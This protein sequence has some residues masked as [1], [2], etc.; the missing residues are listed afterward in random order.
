MIGL[1]N[2]RADLLVPDLPG[3]AGDG[4][5]GGVRHLDQAELRR[6]AVPGLGARDRLA[7]AGGLRGADPRLVPRHDGALRGGGEVPRLANLQ[8]RTVLAGQET[9]GW[10]N[11]HIYLLRFQHECVSK[12]L[13]FTVSACRYQQ[14]VHLQKQSN[15][16][17][18]IPIV[19]SPNN[20][21]ETTQGV[22]ISIFR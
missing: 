18:F 15:A 11:F 20:R 9:G 14:H 6:G 22:I 4:V 1:K 12:L 19:P 3:G 7:A 8:T 2:I 10:T 13:F 5:R 21:A 16:R 17:H